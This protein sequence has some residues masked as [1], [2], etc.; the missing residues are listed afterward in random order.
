MEFILSKQKCEACS[1][2]APLASA[3]QITSL[4]LQIPEWDIVEDDGVQKLRRGFS[5]KNFK[6]A[7][8]FTVRVGEMAEAEGHHPLCIT[9]WGKVEVLWWSHIIGGLHV[10]DFVAAAK[11]DA[12]YGPG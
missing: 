5:F 11:T 9:E 3:E 6:Q 12:L 2:K 7:L 10:N 1:A 8:A 4:H